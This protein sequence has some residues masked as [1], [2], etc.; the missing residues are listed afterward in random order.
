MFFLLK[1]VRFS[2]KLGLLH[3]ERHNQHA[4]RRRAESTN[5]NA[6]LKFA[7]GNQ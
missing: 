6:P 7:G 4:V 2:I 3:D 5:Q 1:N